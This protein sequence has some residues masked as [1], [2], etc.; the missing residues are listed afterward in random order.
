MSSTFRR[1]ILHPERVIVKC[2]RTVMP[3]ELS[4]QGHTIQF[5]I[6][7]GVV[8]HFQFS[9]LS[10]ELYITPH[11]D[12]TKRTISM[13][14]ICALFTVSVIQIVSETLIESSGVGWNLF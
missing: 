2:F 10:N 12:V 13:K 9:F 11:L 4:F 5:P 3:L 6:Y 7:F 8:F 1:G 14:F